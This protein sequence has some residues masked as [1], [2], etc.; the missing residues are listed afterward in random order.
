MSA[1]TKCTFTHLHQQNN[2]TRAIIKT[3]VATWCEENLTGALDCQLSYKRTQL[4]KQ[5]HKYKHIPVSG[6]CVCGSKN[7][8]CVWLLLHLISSQLTS[9]IPFFFILTV[10]HT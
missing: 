6:M 3:L 2:I 8:F 10:N 5:C 4:L 7:E 1:L 9:D